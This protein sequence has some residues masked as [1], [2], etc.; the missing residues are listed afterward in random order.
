MGKEDKKGWK[1]GKSCCME[2]IATMT[3][4]AGFYGVPAESCHHQVSWGIQP[5]ANLSCFLRSTLGLLTLGH[6]QPA[7]SKDWTALHPESP[8]TEKHGEPDTC[9]RWLLGC[10]GNMDGIVTMSATRTIYVSLMRKSSLKYLINFSEMT[11][12]IWGHV[13]KPRCD[14]GSPPPLLCCVWSCA[15]SLSC[16]LLLGSEDIRC[17][18]ASCRRDAGKKYYI[19]VW[20]TRALGK[21]VAVYHGD[22][23]YTKGVA[24]AR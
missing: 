16:L 17:G 9:L 20:T 5:P 11:G 1:A 12:R 6:S 7:L 4:A 10:P 22:N 18:Y 8:L 19:R 13:F 3:P 24:C 23:S 15:L 21:L 14:G 2:G